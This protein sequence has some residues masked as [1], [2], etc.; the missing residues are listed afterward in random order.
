MKKILNNLTAAFFM[1]ILII[2]CNDAA[3]KDIADANTNLK[4]ANQDV[5]GA[6]IATNDTA[7]ANA[8]ANWTSFR[9][10]SDSAI[11][12]MEKDVTRLDEK[13]AKTNNSAK[14]TVKTDLDNT[15]K[16]LQELKERLQ[17]KNVEF[18]NDINQFDATVASKNESFQ[19]EF[20]HDMNGLGTAFKDLFKDN[21]K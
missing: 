20:K 2:S 6:I 13:M 8:I 18:E 21:V 5:K 7:K 15:K 9:N 19:R 4:E 12:G 16:K 14:A 3:K 17:Q 11:A 1:S 10:G